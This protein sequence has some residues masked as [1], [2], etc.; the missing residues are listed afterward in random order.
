MR[1]LILAAI[2]MHF[3]PAA[4]AQTSL[5][6]LHALENR[7]YF[8]NTDSEK[9]MPPALSVR[10]FVVI[11]PP[12]DRGISA[13]DITVS[14]DCTANTFTITGLVSLD[15][16]LKQVSTDPEPTKP[17]AATGPFKTIR[18][19]LCDGNIP[20]GATRYDSQAAALDAGLRIIAANRADPARQ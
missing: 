18:D 12:L 6:T 3:V 5:L 17:A 15:R 14:V 16:E 20:A 19:Y 2:A 1:F 4:M 11:D 7:V 10:T 13:R 8:V 9:G